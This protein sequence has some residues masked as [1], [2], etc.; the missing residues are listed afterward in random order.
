MNLINPIEPPYRV[1]MGFNSV[2][3]NTL[4]FKLRGLAGKR[5]NALDIVIAKGTPVRAPER[6]Q[7]HEVVAGGIKALRGY[8]KF[9]RAISLEDKVTEYIFAH[10]DVVPYPRVGKIWKAGE[11]IA[12]VGSSGWSSGSHL[13]FSMS[14]GGKWID[15]AIYFKNV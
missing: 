9:I 7:V 14:R 2:Y 1:S 6:I 3:P 11:T 15:P 4:F 12:W 8:G 10:L 5:H 13:H